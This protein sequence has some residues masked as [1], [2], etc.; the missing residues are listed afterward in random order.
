VRAPGHRPG[1]LCGLTGSYVPF[2]VTKAERSATGDPRRS[3]QE[4]YCTHDGFVK[5]VS[6]ASSP[7]V[8]ERFLLPVDATRFVSAAQA[9]NVLVGASPGRCDHEDD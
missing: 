2:A 7:L 8:R 4:R 5:A 9:S 6:K 1:N 3:L